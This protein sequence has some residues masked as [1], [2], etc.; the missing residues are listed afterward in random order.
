MMAL[1]NQVML[2]ILIGTCLYM[3]DPFLCLAYV[4]YFINM[5]YKSYLSLLKARKLQEAMWGPVKAPESKKNHLKL[6]KGS[7]D[8]DNK[9]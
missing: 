4:F 7:D 9:L 1:F 6:H 8:D 2:H 5:V 3:H